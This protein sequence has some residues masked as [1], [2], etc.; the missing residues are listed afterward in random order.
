MRRF[1][2][3]LLLLFFACARETPAPPPPTPAPQKPSG[4][5]DGGRVTIRLES[6]VDTLNAVLQTSEDERQVLA[7]VHDPL[8]DLDENANP[9]P[10]T[11]AKW[12]ILDGGKTYVLH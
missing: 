5:V 3:P 9:I 11:A 8:V 12:E 4:P 10:G 7:F 1:A 6:D 2:V